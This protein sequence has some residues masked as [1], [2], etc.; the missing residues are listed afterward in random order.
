MIGAHS[1]TKD[2]YAMVLNV[3]ENFKPITVDLRFLEYNEK[4]SEEEFKEH[5]SHPVKGYEIIKESMHF[6]DTVA[7]VALQHHEKLD[8]SGYPNGI[9]DLTFE[10]QLIGMIDDYEALTYHEKS[11]RDAKEPYDSLSMLKEEVLA[12]KYSKEIFKNFC[13]CLVK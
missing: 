13:S 10:S 1:L 2:E 12:G 8:S 5:Q 9:C 3:L 4:L 6:D 7:T 11:F